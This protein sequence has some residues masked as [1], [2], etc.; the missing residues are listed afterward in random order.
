VAISLSFHRITYSPP[1]RCS[2]FLHLSTFY[3][4]LARIK[5][6]CYN[7]QMHKFSPF[8]IKH[9]KPY[10]SK[11]IGWCQGTAG[12]QGE[13]R[14]SKNSPLLIEHMH[15]QH[16]GK[17]HICKKI[18]T[19]FVPLPCCS[20]LPILKVSDLSRASSHLCLILY[21]FLVAKTPNLEQVIVFGTRR[22]FQSNDYQ[23]MSIEAN[24]YGY[25]LKD[26]N[27]KVHL[28][29]WLHDI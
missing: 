21:L 16:L 2:Q 6:W 20:V 1:S 13:K 26:T 24:Y 18:N 14:L 12:C 8:D 5:P 29:S 19:P 11:N 22:N 9:Q 4:A 17:I 25:Q 7:T 27:C 3:Y 10:S 28:S 23:K 15:Y